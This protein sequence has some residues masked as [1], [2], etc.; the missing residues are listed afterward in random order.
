M[1]RVVHAV[2]ALLHLDLACA[3]DPD[4]RDAAGELG[5]RGGLK[6]RRGEGAG[7]RRLP[8][9][10]LEDMAILTGGQV[11]SDDLGIKRYVRG[12]ASAYAGA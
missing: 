10:M 8:Q 3:A 9:A 12:P 1:Q 2:L 6:G 5:Q 4:H 11:I 7:L